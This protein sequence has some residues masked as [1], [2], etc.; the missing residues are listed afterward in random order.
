MIQITVEPYNPKS[1]IPQ[2][3][4]ITRLVFV[5][6]TPPLYTNPSIMKK[7]RFNTHAVNPSKPDGFHQAHLIIPIL[8]THSLVSSFTR[9]A[10]PTLLVPRCFSLRHIVQASIPIDSSFPKILLLDP[11]PYSASNILPF[12]FCLTRLKCS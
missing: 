3:D 6:K 9:Q 7:L 4:L 11:A 12:C 1:K 8:V 2:N 5:Q 10:Q